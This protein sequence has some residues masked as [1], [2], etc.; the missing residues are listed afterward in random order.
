MNKIQYTK[1]DFDEEEDIVYINI[2]CFLQ[3]GTE[4][5]YNR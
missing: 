2:Y 3:S 5:G 4:G 1:G